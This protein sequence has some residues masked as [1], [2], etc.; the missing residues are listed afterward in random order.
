MLIKEEVFST[1][2]SFEVIFGLLF[3]PFLICSSVK[4]MLYMLT[5]WSFPFIL[6]VIVSV[7]K[8]YL[9]FVVSWFKVYVPLLKLLIKCTPSDVVHSSTTFPLLSFTTNLES[10]I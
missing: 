5:F 10:E 6:N 2:V 3:T 7:F 1:V 9:L 8:K 4:A